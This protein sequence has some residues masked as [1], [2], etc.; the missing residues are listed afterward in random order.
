MILTATAP[1]SV[2]DLLAGGLPGSSRTRL[3]QLLKHG[4]VTLG[5]APVVRADT[6]VPAGGTVE[7]SLGKDPAAGKRFAPNFPVLFE[8]LHLLVVVKPPGL[9]TA[10]DSESQPSFLEYV[11]RYVQENSNGRTRALLVHR[12][13][14]EVSG[15]LVFAKSVAVQQWI[16]DNWK[17]HTKRYL[18]LVHGHPPEDQGTFQSWLWERADQRVVSVPAGTPD[19][20]FAITHYRVLQRREDTTLMEIELDTGRKNQIRVHLSEA[21]C[22]VVGDRRHG[23]D[24]T[25]KRRVRL[26]AFYFDLQHPSTGKHHVFQTEMPEGFLRLK[27]ADEKY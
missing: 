1:T 21:G 17:L 19:A 2:L 26:H 22:P 27:L 10:G 14:R 23:A 13:D 15:I 8:D 7:V 24:A 25:F 16:K 11:T 18:A 9:L 20:K 5:G 6:P 12:L 4:K 3:R